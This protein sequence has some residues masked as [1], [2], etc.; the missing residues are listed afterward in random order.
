MAVHATPRQ[1]WKQRLC[2]QRAK[3]VVSNSPGLVDFAIGPVNPGLDLPKGQ[4]MFLGNSNYRR[5]VINAAHQNFWGATLKTIGLVHI[6]CTSNNLP[7]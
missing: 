7:E 4:V 5:T 2:K 3:K 6:G 1:N